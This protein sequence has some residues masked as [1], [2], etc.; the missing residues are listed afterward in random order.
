[1]AS[2]SSLSSIRRRR[3]KL[4]LIKCPRC[5]QK[6]ILKLTATTATNIGRIFYTCPNHEKGGSG[7]DF[8]YREEGY[9]KYLKRNGFNDQEEDE[10]VVYADVKPAVNWEM[11]GREEEKPTDLKLSEDD[12]L[13]KMTEVILLDTAA[14]CSSPR[15]E[16]R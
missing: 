4:P 2:G 16:E 9:V 5:K 10:Y 12:E 13:K 1:M 15:E 6:N 3:Q 14:P 11:Q 7:C 8:W